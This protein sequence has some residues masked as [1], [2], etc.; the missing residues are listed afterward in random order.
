MAKQQQ[1]GQSSG[2]ESSLDFF[3]LMALVAVGGVLIWYFGKAYIAPVIFSI[4]NYELVAIRYIADIWANIAQ[5]IHLPAP[6]L[7]KINDL[8]AFLATNPKTTNLSTVIDVSNQVGSYM[9]IPFSVIL[10]VL[11]IILYISHITLRF[12]NKFSMNRLK[13]IEHEN[14]PQITPVTNLNL[15]KQDLDE[16]PWAMAMTPLQFAKKNNLVREET[17]GNKTNLVL[18]EGAA[19]RV[20]TLQ[21]GPLW[22]CIENTPIHTQALFAIFACRANRDRESGDKILMQIAA[23]TSQGKLDFTGVKEIVA[24]HLNSPL[25][26]HVIRRHAY[27]STIMAS[28][29]ELARTDGVLGSAEFLWLKPVDRKLWYVLNSVGRQT[30][31]AESAG[32]FA[33]W[34]AEKIIQRAMKVA[35]VDQAVTALK[36]ALADI[37]YEPEQQ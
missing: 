32:A 4:R 36:I 21:L 18:L 23:S 9:M 15:V 10:I 22:S 13:A 28:M 30:P 1:Q 35:M 5:F 31:F 17:I 29:L 19:H 16:G 26:Q 25:V 27:V 2:S 14:W 12:K 3:W 33:H 24:K 20:F 7:D 34:Q 11:A 37:L 6:N 8:Q